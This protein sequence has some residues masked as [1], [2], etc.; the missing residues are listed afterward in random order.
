M[1]KINPFTEKNAI[2]IEKSYEPYAKIG[3]YSYDKATASPYTKT[4]VILMN[5]TEFES[6]WFMH[7]FSRHCM[8]N[9]LRRELALVRRR[10]QQQ[11]K[12]ISSL[13]PLNE[14]ILETTISYEQ[15]AVDLT[16]ILA[17]HAT[18][19]SVKNALCFALLEDFDHLYRFSNLLK[20]EQGIDAKD[21]VKEYTEIM[22]GRPT[23]SEP[24]YPTDEIKK[25]IC[26]N[27]ADPYTRL[28]V[29]I[30]TGAE[31]QTM[32]YYMNVGNIYPT[33]LGRRLY[34]EI[35]MIEE[36]HV[37]QY[38]SLI[39]TTNTMLECWLMHEYTEC[40]LYRSCYEDETDERIKDIWG[41]LYLE[42]CGHLQHVASLLYKY[43]G[44]PWQ[45]LFREGGDFPQLLLFNGN[46][47]FVR[48]VLA[49]TVNITAHGEGYEDICA[50][51]SN[52][53]FF[54]YNSSV[55][56]PDS[57]IASHVVIEKFI[58]KYGTDYRYETDENPIKELSNREEDNI[59]VGRKCK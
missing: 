12:I 32:N 9:D 41:R 21:I 17:R 11:Q 13:K 15:L 2:G 57:K 28:T 46:I 35:A 53:R 43:E 24:R 52:S 47:N 31:Q 7:N 56:K 26:S 20:M 37:T 36:Q 18:D 49:K 38:G 6:N 1:Q 51:P 23:I 59:T 27:L 34:S 19:E 54:K 16:A 29:N 5:G 8:N 22:P 58:S 10:E 50:L 55:T 33:S 14:S 42:E 39:D 4:R 45:S 48:D 25:W 44:K 30:I 40:Y 3:N